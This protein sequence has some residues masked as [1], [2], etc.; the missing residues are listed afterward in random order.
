MTKM[1]TQAAKTCVPPKIKIQ[2][3]KTSEM[4]LVFSNH[5]LKGKW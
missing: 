5:L 4:K 3:S 2:K 1:K